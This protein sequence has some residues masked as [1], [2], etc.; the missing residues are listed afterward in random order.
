MLVFALQ[1]RYWSNQEGIQP[2][3]QVVNSSTARQATITGLRKFVWYE[4][5][6]LGYTRIGDGTLSQPPVSVQTHADGKTGPGNTYKKQRS[7]C[8]IRSSLFTLATTVFQ[9]PNTILQL[10]WGGITI[11]LG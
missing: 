9:L 6:V 7:R 5:Q 10:H 11:L 2:V 4:L 3:M 8:K 1:I